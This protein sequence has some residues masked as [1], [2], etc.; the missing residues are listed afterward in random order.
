M[1]EYKGFT[2]KLFCLVKVCDQLSCI[3]INVSPVI[4]CITYKLQR[5]RKKTCTSI[6]YG[7]AYPTTLT[8]VALLALHVKCSTAYAAFSTLNNAT[9]S[10]RPLLYPLHGDGHA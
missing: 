7:T 2:Q 1:S 9:G 6:P 4:Y 3:N 10:S 8:T 5:K